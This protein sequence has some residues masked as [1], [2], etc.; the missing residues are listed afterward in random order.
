MIRRVRD[1]FPTPGIYDPSGGA[2]PV[3]GI[4]DEAHQEVSVG[5]DGVAVTTTKPVYELVLA[6]LTALGITPAV[7]H[8]IQIGVTKF[9]V[10]DLRPDGAG[11]V[12]M[13]LLEVG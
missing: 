7:G 4:F 11:S 6:D 3:V 9:E 2:H 10:A 1:K 8:R 12:Q 5:S 13:P